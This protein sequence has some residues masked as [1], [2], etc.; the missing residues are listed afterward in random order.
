MVLYAIDFL[1]CPGDEILFTA[2]TI[3]YQRKSAK[4]EQ[5]LIWHIRV[6]KII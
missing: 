2:K 4:P 6:C 3:I 1:L 5:I